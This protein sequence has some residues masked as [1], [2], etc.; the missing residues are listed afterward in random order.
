MTTL[1]NLNQKS[2]Q[3]LYHK[4]QL[5]DNYAWFYYISES[6]EHVPTLL[7]SV[8][9]TENL[10]IKAY[11][12]SA[13]LPFSAYEHLMPSKQLQSITQFTNI[14]SL[15]KSLTDE[16]Y[17]GF[18]NF[19]L[20]KF[21]IWVFRQ[22]IAEEIAEH[23]FDNLLFALLKFVVEQLKLVQVSKHGRHYLSSLITTSFLW[24]MTSM[25]LYKKLRHLL[26]LPSLSLLQKLSSDMTVQ[27]GKLDLEYLKLRQIDLSQQQKI[28]VLLSGEVH[29]AQRVE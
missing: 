5:K 8:L 6:A 20:L 12:I 21:A 22:V 19:Y 25:S 13:V 14:L 7:A 24:Q 17:R 4:A 2:E 3:K 23:H 26:L 16:N 11:V 10:K 1:V 28:V 9:V 27:S 15:C 29:T 18:C